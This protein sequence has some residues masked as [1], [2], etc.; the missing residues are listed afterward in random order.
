MNKFAGTAK[1]VA[2]VGFGEAAMAFVNGWGQDRPEHIAAFDTKTDA[3]TTRAEMESRYAA[4]QVDG[5][6]SVVGALDGADPIFSLVTADQALAAAHTAAAGGLPRGS[7]W[8]DC[9]SCAPQ[10]K[11]A[12]AEVIEL[13]GGRYVD[14][15][16]MA[17]VH[18][19]QHQV[20][21]L[22]AGPHSEAALSV[23]RSLNMKPTIAGQDVGQASYIKMLRSVMIKGMEALSAECFLAAH[24]AGVLDA[25]LGSLEAS[26]PGVRWREQGAYN[27]E[28]M[29]VHGAR[30]AAEMREVSSTVEGLGLFGGMSKA[31]AQWQ[32][33]ISAAK[34]AP[35]KDD[36]R[37]RA[38]RILSC[39]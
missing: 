7:L 23:L 20:P 11:Q 21:L 13:A 30:R 15:A 18:A 10:T 26:N 19:L 14:V 36:L 2:F 34:A 1:R 39:L 32:D 29:M 16:V 27:L 3:E 9:N 25:V 24:K 4:H 5:H 22:V 33:R 31:A 37:L 12:A 38:E 35:G 17:P 6:N 8:F 28:R